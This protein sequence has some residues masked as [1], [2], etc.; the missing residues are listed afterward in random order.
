MIGRSVWLVSADGHSPPLANKKDYKDE[1][2]R[3]ALRKQ[4]SLVRSTD[5][6]LGLH[7]SFLA[8]AARLLRWR[9]VYITQD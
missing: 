2:Q 8:H 4:H 1:E 6:G 3:E 7:S 9:E 5:G